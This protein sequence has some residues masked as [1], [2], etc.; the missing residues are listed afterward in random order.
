M[1]TAGKRNSRRRKENQGYVPD[2]VVEQEGISFLQWTADPL[3][4]IL[5]FDHCF[6]KK[7]KARGVVAHAE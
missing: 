1:V 4:M 6:I 5:S 2:R 7:R 3:H